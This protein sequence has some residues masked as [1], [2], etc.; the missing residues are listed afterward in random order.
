MLKNVRN[1]T[2][3]DCINVIR[4][5]ERKLMMERFE[6]RKWRFNN[7]RRKKDQRDEE[8]DIEPSTKI[9]NCL[10]YTSDAADE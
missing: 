3:R 6:K 9:R 10:L 5:Q 4:I 2:L 8:D 7:I 1:I